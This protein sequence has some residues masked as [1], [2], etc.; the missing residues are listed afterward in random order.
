MKV[1]IKQVEASHPLD[2]CN[3]ITSNCFSIAAISAGLKHNYSKIQIIQ[4]QIYKATDTSVLIT[5]F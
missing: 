2:A 3:W 5:E 4:L 1:S